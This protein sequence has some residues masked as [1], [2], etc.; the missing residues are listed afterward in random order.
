MFHCFVNYKVKESRV[1]EEFKTEQFHVSA[2]TEKDIRNIK[3]I[4]SELL[5]R[6]GIEHSYKIIYVPVFIEKEGE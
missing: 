6:L 1:S 4:I 2:E 3:D 5:D